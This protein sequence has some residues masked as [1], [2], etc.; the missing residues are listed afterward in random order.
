MWCKE[1]HAPFYITIPPSLLPIT[2]PP[3]LSQPP[4]INLV[5]C[6]CSTAATPNTAAPPVQHSSGS[7]SLRV[8]APQKIVLQECEQRGG[9]A[10]ALHQVLHGGAVLQHGHTT[11]GEVNL[12]HKE[13]KTTSLLSVCLCGTRKTHCA[14]VLHI[15]TSMLKFV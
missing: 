6:C 2:P 5:V 12:H 14:L 9:S 10:A 15:L 13:G 8:N 3:P 11:A 4:H 1:D 7:V